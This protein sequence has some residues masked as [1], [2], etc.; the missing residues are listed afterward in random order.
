[1]LSPGLKIIAAAKHIEGWGPDQT[2]LQVGTDCVGEG[3][4]NKQ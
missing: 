1:M 2:C 3:P 4:D